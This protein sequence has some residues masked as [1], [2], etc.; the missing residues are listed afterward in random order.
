MANI[1]E[2]LSSWSATAASNQPD[3]T[4]ANTIVADLQAIQATMRKYLAT[5]DTIA[6]GT[7]VDLSTVGGPFVSVTHSTG[8][9]AISSLGT[10]SAGM[11]KVL[12]FAISG[13]ALSLTHHSTQLILPSAANIT[14]ADG[15]SLIA[16]SLGSGDWKVHVFQKASGLPVIAPATQAEQETGTNVIA[17]VTPGR[18]QYH[19]SA[20]KA[21]ANWSSA[22]AINT[23]HNVSSVTDSGAGDFTVNFTVAFSAVNY[24]VVAI[25][26]DTNPPVITGFGSL[27]TGAADINTRVAAGTLTDS[28]GGYC[29]AFYGDL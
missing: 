9:T 18:Q 4:D 14:L 11:W 20:A 27:A 15:D 3:S 7:T 28:S 21:W 25:A 17:A 6:S 10:L 26:A 5:R 23:S 16:E 24:T 19:P 22:G 13:G 8:T 1:V 29:A 2:N 12:T